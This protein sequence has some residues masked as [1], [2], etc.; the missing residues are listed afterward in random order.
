MAREPKT[1]FAPDY[2]R[3]LSERVYRIL[4][5]QDCAGN[6][7]RMI[8]KDEDSGEKLRNRA[9]F[10]DRLSRT[11]LKVLGFEPGQN[12]EPTPA[13]SQQERQT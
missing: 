12:G 3:D 7:D 8:S 13:Q 6:V 4:L 5:E 10:Y 9:G 1:T 2:V 11:Y